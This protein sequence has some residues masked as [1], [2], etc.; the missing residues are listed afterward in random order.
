MQTLLETVGLTLSHFSKIALS[1][2]LVGV[3]GCVSTPPYEEYTLA[4]EALR[5]AEEADSAKLSAA[6]W[7]KAEG[8]YREAEQAYK[9]NQF[10]LARKKFVTARVLAEKAENQ[11]RLKKFESGDVFQ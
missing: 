4:R 5:A 7:M 1:L 8:A 11:T 6:F 3:V 10:D 9:E 2:V